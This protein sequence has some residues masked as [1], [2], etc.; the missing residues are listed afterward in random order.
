MKKHLFLLAAVV[1][2]YC[3][4][5]VSPVLAH[6]I[7]LH[8]NPAPNAVLA[9][10]PAQVEIYFSETLQPGLSSIAV[11]DSNGAVVDLG[12]VRVDPNDAT[13]LTV[14]LRSLS[15][16]VYTVS[17]K[18]VSA[19]D[20]H[21]TTGSFPFAV[22]NVNSSDLAAVQPTSTASLPFSALLAKW[23]LLAA[24]AVLAG[25]G[26]FEAL[27]WN[28]ALKA[29][30]DELTPE[31]RQPAIWDTLYQLGW[32][33]VLVSSVVGLLSEAG[34]ATGSELAWP[35]ARETGLLL[36]ESRLG[37]IWL[38]RL[39]LVLLGVWFVR[40]RP[41]A[42]KAWAGFAVSLALLFTVSLSSHAA[43]EAHPVLPV[44]ADWLHLLGMSFW[45]GGLAYL[46]TGLREL[47]RVSGVLRTRLTALSISRFSIMALFSVGV[48]GL[49]G[50]YAA[51]LRVGTLDALET[52]LYGHVLFIKQGFVVALLLLAAINLLFISPRLKRDRIGN[53]GNVPLVMNF[54]K[55]VRAEIILAC[56]LLLTV[57]LLTYLPPAK[58]NPPSSDLTAAVDN[59]D[60]RM[61]ITISPGRVG[62]N[63]FTLHVLSNGQPL[64]SAKEILLRFTPG[65]SNIPPSEVQLIGQG[66]GDFVTK[67]SYVS[68]PGNWQ[69]Q[70]VV[71]RADKF[72][73]YANF[74]FAIS[75]PG[76]D[77]PDAATP[78][79]VGG[80]LLLDGLLFGLLMLSTVK[81]PFLRLGAGAL[82]A[83]LLV[84]LG[85]I[86]FMTPPAAT[87]GQANPVLPDARSVAA[88]QALF[89][90]YCVP[91]HGETGKGD[92]PLGL[93]LNP[94]PADLTY[95]AI[96]G[97]HTDAQLFEWI[98][99]GFPGSRMPAFKA[100][101]S[102]TDRWNLV[103]FIR[104]LA[105]KK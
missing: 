8:S 52:S 16:G 85:V 41:V 43:T 34:Q 55:I 61:E 71:R 62:Q 78:K 76:S 48:I 38:V 26:C 12:D 1:V 44:L 75:S 33:A 50:L 25:R 94:R 11:Y 64:Q 97:I 6:A 54:E 22:G 63:T 21:F 105:P 83:F 80:L 79:I 96:A 37:V 45:F 81:T 14:S 103:N 46:F 90:N 56:F 30:G 7:F 3:A 59:D 27:V 72:D 40:S 28:P 67:G 88:G 36:T 99:N 32:I 65:Q 15:D 84:I 92:G 18:V 10:S 73:S 98:S 60:L 51:S 42:W 70:A 39:G 2:L 49:T 5:T 24:L 17:W 23:L 35:W 100:R 9:S 74:N 19:T 87:N 77:N 31:V 101:L 4:W 102:D 20:G 29:T 13:R 53:A 68:L 89:S 104:T 66:N 91:C 93:T 58:V 57:S 69:I 82:P 86:T 47:Q 95:H